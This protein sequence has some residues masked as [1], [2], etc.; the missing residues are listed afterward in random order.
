MLT[1]RTFLASA[2]LIALPLVTLPVMAAQFETRQYESD[3]GDFYELKDGT[4]IKLTGY[5]GYIGYMGYAEEMAFLDGQVCIK[6]SRYD[7]ELYERGSASHYSATTYYGAEAYAKMEEV[8]G[9]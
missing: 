8:C 3:S 4:V 1:T 2:C 6:G 9:R 5:V 7:Y